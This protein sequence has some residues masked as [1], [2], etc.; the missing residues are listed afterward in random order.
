MKI[1]FTLQTVY[2]SY[3][4]TQ[5]TFSLFHT[6]M[7]MQEPLVAVI[8]SLDIPDLATMV[9]VGGGNLLGRT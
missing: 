8:S 2:I 9:R 1:P 3:S 5:A 6:E 4:A 7:R